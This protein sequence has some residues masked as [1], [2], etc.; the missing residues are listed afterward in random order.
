MTDAVKDNNSINTLL[1]TQ[2][3]DGETPE[4][5]EA[6]PSSNALKVADAST[7]S[8][9]SSS[10]EAKRDDNKIAV[11]MAVSSVDGVTPVPVYINTSGELLIDS[12]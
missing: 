6:D 8:D 12:N 7:G 4:K 10:N 5:V 3:T 1:A 11:I 9:N 2:Q